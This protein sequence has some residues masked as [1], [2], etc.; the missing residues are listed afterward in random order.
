MKKKIEETTGVYMQSKSSG[1]IHSKLISVVTNRLGNGIVGNSMVIEILSLILKM[2]S[3]ILPLG[4]CTGCSFCLERHSSQ[5]YLHGWLLLCQ[6][7]AQLSPPQR[8]SLIPLSKASIPRWK[9]E[10]LRD[11]GWR[12][13]SL[14][15]ILYPL[16]VEPTELITTQKIN[17]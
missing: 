17:E 13:T 2:P 5:G 12:K 16:N 15:T 11:R 4:Y 6:V 9:I 1:K 14:Y 7:S 8:S 3:S 10:W